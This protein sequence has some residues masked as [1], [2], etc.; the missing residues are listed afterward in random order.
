MEVQ[1]QAISRANSALQCNLNWMTLHSHQLQCKLHCANQQLEDCTKHCHQLASWFIQTE[2]HHW[3]D[4]SA[5]LPSTGINSNEN[6][7]CD[8]D[9]GTDS[10][11]STC[12]PPE[13][14]VLFDE[15]TQDGDWVLIP[16]DAHDEEHQLGDDC[17]VNVNLTM[18]CLTR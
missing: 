2:Q 1:L 9:D 14:C 5:E 11:G 8:S 6:D 12:V 17:T 10:G 16:E 4:M 15:D 7:S 3:Q 13:Q 18:G